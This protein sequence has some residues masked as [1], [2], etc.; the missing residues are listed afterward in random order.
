MEVVTQDLK[1]AP[2]E[3]KLVWRTKEGFDLLPFYREED[4]KDLPTTNVLPGVYPYV[5]GTKADN[6]W[7]IRQE[8]DGALESQAI[9]DKIA[10]LLGRGVNSF[11]IHFG[12][13]EVTKADV[14]TILKGLD[15]NAV[16]INYYCCNRMATE[17]AK[18]LVEAYKEVGADL[19]AVQG[20]LNFN[21]FRRILRKGEEQAE[22]LQV[23][24]EVTQTIAPLKNFTSLTIR[25]V[26]LVNAGAYIHQELGYALAAAADT[27][28]KVADESGL[29][30]AEVARRIRFDMGVGSN[31]FMEMAKF[32]ALRWL[33]AT[34]I[35]ANGIAST[36]DACKA[37]V[38]AETALWNKTV[39]DAHVNLLRTT[40]ES[41]SAILGG[42][43]SFSVLPF[44]ATYSWGD[45]F[46]ERIARNQQL[47][48]KE[49]SHF[50]KVVDPAGGSYYVEHLT[51]SIAQEAWKLFLEVE[52]AGGFAQMA[53]EGKIQQAVNTSNAER[54]KAVATRKESLLGTNI[55]PNFTETATEEK[56]AVSHAVE[57]GIKVAALDTRRGASDFEELRM[58]T[59]RSGKTPKVFMLTIGNLAMRLA[60]SQFSANFF[61]VAGYKIIDN[62]GFNTIKEGIEAARAQKADIV[63]LC[64]SDDEYAEYGP[65]AYD[66]LKGEIPLVIAGAPACME[67]LKAK[68]IEHFVHVRCNVLETMQGFSKLLGITKGK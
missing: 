37:M 49:E 11:G 43:H 17:L 52:E 68:G 36:D 46:S 21:P 55:F 50:D 18:A 60:R 23:A 62:L 57:Q 58:A 14:V 13:K 63:C 59:E 66:E 54:H 53:R 20:S 2:F 39:Y 64:S 6:H 29:E 38:H 42:V 48:L 25:G 35:T 24:A 67:D 26:D 9:H 45:D 10:Y 40:T 61:G 15:L 7:W 28:Q 1:G 41:M 12:H 27:L 19:K 16:E 44:N 51:V 31:Y 47:L 3:K 22:W 5:R 56:L 34:I 30:L 8:L 4:I 33:W 65:Q 32:R